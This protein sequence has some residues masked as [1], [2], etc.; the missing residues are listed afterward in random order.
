MSAEAQVWSKDRLLSLIKNKVE[1]HLGLDYKAGDALD[2][3]E[4]KKTEI[5]KDVSAFANSAGGT[6]IYGI[7]EYEVDGMRLPSKIEPVNAA[8]FPKERLEQIV[9]TIRPKIEGVVITVVRVGDSANEV[10]YIVEIPQSTTAHQAKDHRYYKR[11]N[12]L[13]EPM[14]DYEIRDILMRQR[15]PQIEV[16]FQLV[17]MQKAS[18]L[19]ITVANTGSVVAHHVCAY[20]RLPMRLQVDTTKKDDFSFTMESGDMFYEAYLMNIHKDLVGVKPGLRGF[21]MPGAGSI[22]DIPDTKYYLT[23]YDPILPKMNRRYAYGL[24]ISAKEVRAGADAIEWSIYVDSAPAKN[25][26]SQLKDI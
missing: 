14:E 15:H 19:Y 6:I 8:E 24:G 20:V 23:R 17:D 5:T 2:G 16:G 4:K 18:G 25:G 3:T 1:E 7:A 12:F 13:S 11:R 26:F 9:N 10:C 21:A 22:P